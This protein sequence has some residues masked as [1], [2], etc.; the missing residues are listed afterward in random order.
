MRR[1]NRRLVR[2]RNIGRGRFLAALFALSLGS[3]VLTAVAAPAVADVCDPVTGNAIACENLQ[4]GTLKSEWDV[5]NGDTDIEGFTTDISTNVGGTV[6]F[7]IH[8]PAAYTVEIF[9]MGYYGG[10]GARRITTF[11]PNP[12]VAQANES[13]ACLNKLDTGLIDCGTWGVSAT[14]AVPATAVSGIYF[15]RIAETAHPEVENQIVFVVRNSAS[16]SKMIFQTSDTT[17]QA[18]N[19]WGG[20]SFYEG[21]PAGRAYK[22]SYN[23]PFNTRTTPGGRDFVWANEYPMVRFLEANGYDVTYQSG[24]DTD[25]F[26]SQLIQHRVFLSV[27]H[28]EYWSGAQRTNVE[29]ARDAGVNLAF[30]SANEV[31]WKTRYESSLPETGGQS[32]RTIVTY[33]ESKNN[34][35]NAN[36]PAG[37]WTGTWRDPRFSPP[38]DGGRPE[39]ALTGN[40]FT[41]NKGTRALQVPAADGKLRFW[42]GT[43]PSHLAAGQTTTMPM[44]TLGYEWDEDL[45]NGFRPAGAIRMSSS[46]YSVPEKLV[47]YGTDV[48]PATATHHLMLYR[49][50]SGAL[51]FGAGTVQWSWGLD[52]EHDYPQDPDEL[53]PNG[54]TGA[55]TPAD[56]NMQQATVNLLADMDAQPSTLQSPLVA[57]TKSTDSTPAAAQITAPAAGAS[58]ASGS[59]V[60]VSGTASDA[61]GGQVGGVEVSTDGG[62]T[63]HPANGRESWTYTWNVTGAGPTTLLARATDDSANRQVT[64]TQRQVQ[65]ACPCALFGSETP[66]VASDPDTNSL[67]LGVRFSPK[68]DGYVTGIRF[69]KGPT[70]TGVHTGTLWSDGGTELATGTFVGESTGGWQNLQFNTAVPVTAGTTYVASYHAP[71]GGYSTTSGY[72]AAGDKQQFPLSAPKTTDGTPNGVY[73]SGD[74]SF[75]TRT[76]GGG[77]YWVTPVFDLVQPPDTTAPVAISSAPVDGASSVKVTAAPK[78]T[79]SEPIKAGTLTLGLSSANGLVAGATSLNSNRTTATFTPAVPLANATTYTFTTTGGTD[80]AGNPLPVSSRTFRT[81]ASSVP[82]VCPCSIWSDSDEPT[83]VTVNDPSPVE[84]GV[85][86]R[87]DQNMWFR[88]T[89]AG[90]DRFMQ[91]QKL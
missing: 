56:K 31:F 57:A 82:G 22:L 42:R 51:V 24:V 23:R 19:T 74:R 44:G 72:F 67:E 84:L 37:T 34:E 36:N 15:A 3:V 50:P 54:P 78:L 64:P 38:A 73:E 79:F 21:E 76:F 10:R 85:K 91:A 5:G 60:T 16:T 52:A 2:V 65:V 81:A 27:G 62:Q 46:T 45:D 87:A 40:I 59:A 29:A 69:Y 18:Y 63:W 11:T 8:S 83:A 9:R 32:Y 41:V 6:S 88:F 7:K 49:A 13:V 77:N 25:R 70:N 75:P 71:N 55:A 89:E 66:T 61:G 26:G 53:D 39:N 43:D 68:I 58:V 28:D 86:F 4:T 20:N 12:A 17:W 14:W 90:F 80:D 1:G 33:K 47:G 30:F 35:I 48:E